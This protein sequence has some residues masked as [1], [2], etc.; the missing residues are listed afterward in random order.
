MSY[1]RNYASAVFQ[2]SAWYRKPLY[3]TSGFLPG[4]PPG[5]AAVRQCLLLVQ[6][7]TVIDVEGLQKFLLRSQNGNVGFGASVALLTHDAALRQVL[8][9][10]LT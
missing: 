4:L 5:T 6:T 2:L 9:N 8:V 7:R 1:L 10:G 3:S